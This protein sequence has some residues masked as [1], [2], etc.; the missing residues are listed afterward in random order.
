MARFYYSQRRYEDALS[1]YTRVIDLTP[2]SYRAYSDRGAMY[3]AL[4]R[5]EE[6]RRDLER[7]LEIQPS[8][9]A[10]SNLGSLYFSD[11]RYSDAAAKYAKALEFN[12]KDYRLWGNLASAYFWTP[13]EDRKTEAR[14]AYEQAALLAEGTLKINPQDASVLTNLS[15]YYAMLGRR[16]KAIPLLSRALELTPADNK[17]V[18]RAAEIHEQLGDR[19]MALKFI[20]RAL[21]LGYSKA[22]IERSPNLRQL[23]ADPGFQNLLQQRSETLALLRFTI[24]GDHESRSH[25]EVGRLIPSTSRLCIRSRFL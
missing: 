19:Q 20:A 22:V 1:Y 5:R 10:Y 6:A 7:S 11:E 15:Q 18:F 21:A 23:R 4:E 14:S 25:I 13:E 9:G 17:L 16:D 2:D 12:A 24:P 8:Y 3:V